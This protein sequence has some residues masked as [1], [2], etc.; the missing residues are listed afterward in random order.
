MDRYVFDVDGTL[1]PSRQKI[2]PSMEKVFLEFIDEFKVYLVT[3]SD[4]VKTVEQ[5]GTEIVEKVEK[6]YNCSGSDV[7]QNGK[8]IKKSDWKISSEIN[9]WLDDTLLDSKYPVRTG[10]HFEERPGLVNFSIV[11]RN[12]NMEQRKDYV[13]YD[14]E[15]GERDEIVRKFNNVFCNVEASAGGETGIDIHPKGKDKSQIIDDFKPNDTIH[16]FGDRMDKDGNDYSLSL[17]A[18]KNYPVKSWEETYK[19]VYD[20]LLFGSGQS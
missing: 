16:F 20:I 10:N 11:G 2:L 3:G 17:K 14:K 19:I 9:M 15:T 6:V 4:Y 18:T 8:N 13:K 7:W 1:T 12:A 5:L